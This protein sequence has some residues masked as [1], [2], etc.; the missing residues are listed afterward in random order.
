MQRKEQALTISGEVGDIELL[1]SVPSANSAAGL[2]VV[3]HPHSLQGG[4]MQNK[5]VTT[6]LRSFQQ[7]GLAT[8]RFNFRGVGQSQGSYDAGIGE[9]RD[10]ALLLHWAQQRLSIAPEKT[11]LAGF[12]FGSYV[13]WRVAATEKLAQLVLVAP[14]VNHFD[15]TAVAMPTTPC[16]VVM[17]EQDE[18]V[19]CSEVKAWVASL[20]PKPDLALFADSSHFFHGKLILLKETLLSK[21]A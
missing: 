7:L 5:V 10:C 15:F 11:Y 18:V 3:C 12:S 20:Q 8:V 19:S 1:L 21:L 4:T 6:L 14:P 13:V 17:G 9:A 2:A 16:L